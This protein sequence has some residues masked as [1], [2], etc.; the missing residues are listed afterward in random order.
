MNSDKRKSV[1][2]RALI[3]FV[4]TVSAGGVYAQ[5]KK[6]PPKPK[7]ATVQNESELAK[8]HD[9][10][11][12]ATKEYKASL[13]KLVKS[14]QDSARKAEERVSQLRKLLAEG[15]VSRRDVEQ[16]EST[17]ADANLKV[18][19]AQQQIA[20]ADTQIAQVFLEIEG[21]K[22]IAKLGRAGKGRLLTTASFIRYTGAGSWVLSQAGRVES[23]FQQTFKRPLPIAVFG[24]GAIHN[25]WRLDHRNAMDISLN[26]DGAEGQ[27][28]MQ[29]LRSNGIP[30]SA[31]RGAIPGVATGP[32]IHI[33]APSHRY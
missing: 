13:E 27:A 9:R 14:Y 25:Q 23:F 2:V 12:Q 16:S 24:Q 22:E 3:S 26:P 8:L 10:Y 5:K 6:S 18:L 17:L 32:H 30:F 20:T 29:F 4:V 28:L 1:W 31:F 33:G 7:P 11:I 15:L 19:G 21:D